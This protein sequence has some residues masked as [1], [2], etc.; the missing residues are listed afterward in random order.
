MPW[1]AGQRV[2]A[3]ALN[4]SSPELIQ[5]VSIAVTTASVTISIPTGYNRIEVFW[6]ARMSD[7]V[8][9]EQ[10]YLRM[11]GDTS[12]H[13]LWEVNQANN[14][15]VAATTSGAAVAQI[16]IAT[17]TGNSATALYFG[18]GSFTIDGASDAVNYKTMQGTSAAFGTTTNMWAGVY[19]GQWLSAAV[20]TSIT[21]FGATG[22]FLAGSNVTAYG[23]S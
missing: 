11:N 22:S 12:A 17:V 19:S 6:R 21:L 15:T 14:T 18:A 8:A 23:L 9:A 2:T 1:Y 3:A 16:Q 7:A 10:L 5:A 20:V 4:A 13:Y